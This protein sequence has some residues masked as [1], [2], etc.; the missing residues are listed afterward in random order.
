MASPFLQCSY[1]T[2]T[3]C[4]SGPLST[5]NTINVRFDLNKERTEL[6][7]VTGSPGSCL[8]LKD[9]FVLCCSLLE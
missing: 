5:S 3:E 7:H 1:C 2:E 8:P 4:T 6:V 9:S